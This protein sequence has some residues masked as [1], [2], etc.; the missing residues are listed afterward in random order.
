METNT[1]NNG[2]LEYLASF[3]DKLF[4][5]K[6]FLILKVKEIYNGN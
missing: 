5:K 1:L 2:R 3:S 6:L 4:M